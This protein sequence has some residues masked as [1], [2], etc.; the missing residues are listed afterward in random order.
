MKGNVEESVLNS[1]LPNIETY[2]AT[3]AEHFSVALGLYLIT[4]TRL[5]PTK[6]Q[7]Y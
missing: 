6:F 4:N 2:R 3:T 1:T 7:I 5:N